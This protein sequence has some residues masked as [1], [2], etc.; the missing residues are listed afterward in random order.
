MIG[1]IVKRI[2]KPTA[3]ILA[4]F[5]VT[6]FGFGGVSGAEPLLAVIRNTGPDS[7]NSITAQ[8][9]TICT[10]DNDN[11]ITINNNVD[12]SGQSGDAEASGNTTV[13]GWGAWDPVVWQNNGYSYAQWQAAFAAYLQSNQ[14]TWQAQWGSLTGSGGA[15]SGNVSNSNVVAVDVAID[16]SSACTPRP[17]S[18]PDSPGNPD[19]PQVLGQQGGVGA[20]AGS[21]LGL[22]NPNSLSGGG[23]FLGGSSG[24]G[25]GGTGGG[26]GGSGPTPDGLSGGCAAS[27]GNTGPDSNNSILCSAQNTTTVN[28][29]NNVSAQLNTS[30]SAGSGGA[31]VEGNGGSGDAVSGGVSNQSTT[32]LDFSVQN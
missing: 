20:A 11:Q 18:G 27:I 23:F 28:N 2:P 19:T 17:D 30:Q 16:N 13:S 32:G 9:E 22:S 25:S 10:A 29:N 5:G 1:R 12:Q 3:T 6:V 21:S 15:T 4:I 24:S 14:A 8:T 26:N 7:D 31:T